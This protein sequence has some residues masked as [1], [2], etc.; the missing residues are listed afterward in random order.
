[1]IRR[2]KTVVA[3][4]TLRVR[5]NSRR[6]V[7]MIR[8]L[9][10]AIL[11]LA[12]LSCAVRRPTQRESVIAEYQ[13]S[14]RAEV[15]SALSKILADRKI[16]LAKTDATHGSIVTDSFEVIPEYCDCG[17]NFFGVQYPGTRRGQMRITISGAR[18]IT[19]KFEF[20]TLLTIR[21]NNRQ[22]KCTSFGILENEILQQLDQALG[23]VRENAEN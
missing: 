3:R 18:E 21:A 2:R 10:V 7:C 19:I 20:G 12:L 6:F 5:D 14:K 22:V 8:W 15:L 11:G 1:M 16:P 23:V 17:M 13:H 4:K 9:V